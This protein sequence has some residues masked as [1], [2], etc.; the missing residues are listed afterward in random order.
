MADYERRR[1]WTRRADDVVNFLLLAAL[2]PVFLFG[3]YILWD[4]HQS[5]AAADASEFVQYKPNDRAHLSFAELQ[6]LNGDVFA[7]LTLDDTKV[8][9]PVV[10]GKDN[11]HYVNT[12]VYGDF[13]L[14]GAIFL[15]HRNARNMS[16]AASILY[17]HHIEDD[18]MFGGFDHYED[19]SYFEAHRDGTLIFAGGTSS[20]SAS[21]GELLAHPLHVFAFFQADGYDTSVYNTSVDSAEDYRK[22]LDGILAKAGTG[23]GHIDEAS[24]PRL[25]S[26]A[27]SSALQNSSGLPRVVLLSTCQSA[28]TNQ[29]MLLAC[30]L[31]EGEALPETSGEAE[32]THRQRHLELGFW[33]W[34]LLLLVLL[35]L[36]LVALRLYLK[37][38]EGD[39]HE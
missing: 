33:Q 39:S 10:Q 27:A 31:G 2:I 13:S 15:D 18:V 34:M 26:V 24:V 38:K 21:S 17:G 1:R 14:G 28:E 37:K 25:G 6:E 12:D 20:D 23:I 29:R 16:D 9:Y 8:D 32:A 22:W 5:T 3:G 7:W 35:I 36:A 30:T 11:T 4:G 19:A